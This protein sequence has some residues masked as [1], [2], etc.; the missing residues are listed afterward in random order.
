MNGDAVLGFASLV[1][2]LSGASYLGNATLTR[3][4]TTVTGPFVGTTLPEN[5]MVWQRD[6]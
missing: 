6:R 1:N 4:K 5:T 2:G 3:F